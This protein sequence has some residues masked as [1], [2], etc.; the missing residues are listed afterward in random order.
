MSKGTLI[1][2]AL[3]FFAL[4]FISDVTILIGLAFVISL[5]IIFS[6]LWV[7]FGEKYLSVSVKSERIAYFQGDEFEVYYTIENR[8]FLPYT[9][10]RLIIAIHRNVTVENIT[11]KRNEGIYNFYQL[12]FT[13]RPRSKVAQSITC[14]T[15]SRGGYYFDETYLII[16][17]QFLI[18][19]ATKKNFPIKEIAIYP[20]IFSINSIKNQLN[21]IYGNKKINISFLEDRIL[22]KGAREYLPTDPFTKIDWKQ[23]SKYSNLFT[24]QYEYTAH[25]EFLILANLK[26]SDEVWMGTD[27]QKVERA[28]STVASLAYLFSKKGLSYHILM[29]AKL[30]KRNDLF[31]LS[32]NT[33]EDLQ[34]ILYQ[35]AKLRSYTTVNYIHTLRSIKKY[36]G[37]KK[38]IIILVSSYLSKEVEAQITKLKSERY[39]IIW[40]DINNA[41][42]AENGGLLEL[43][44]KTGT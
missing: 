8:S 44:F 6:I 26:T 36:H 4:G 32:A 28:I 31:K 25:Q 2:V 23:T 7:Y 24:K 33:Q 38:P 27:E 17:D 5:L 19:E 35:L 11:P 43:S 30:V 34:K 9:N 13:L 20:K 12:N 15:K 18:Y 16:N 37:G 10:I 22:P 42:E 39:K 3:I 29:N 21:Q 1:Y 41:V 14:S 40:I